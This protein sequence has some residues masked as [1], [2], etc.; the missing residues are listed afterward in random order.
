MIIPPPFA[1]ALASVLSGHFA[2]PQLHWAASPIELGLANLSSFRA[3][4]TILQRRGYGRVAEFYLP[5][6][7]VGGR[8]A[9]PDINI[10]ENSVLA[11]VAGVIAGLQAVTPIHPADAELERIA[12]GIQLWGGKT[13]R[14][15]FVRGGGFHHNFS[16]HHY[17]QIIGHLLTPLSPGEVFPTP[18]I[19]NA[20]NLW[21]AGDFKQIG[22]S[23]ATKHLG[24][25]S[26]GPDAP[27]RLP[28]Y[29]SIMAE[30]FMGRFSVNRRTNMRRGVAHWGD[31]LNYVNGMRA[32]VAAINATNPELEGQYTE[33]QLERQLFV[34][35]GTPA[36]EAWVRMN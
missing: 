31:Y 30:K 27:T 6:L 36:A 35:A 2:I 22:V 16:F 26:R 8:P 23:F 24:F 1:P 3:M 21:E 7:A 28:I 34:W 32:A 12:I 4:F 14:S 19:H 13:G 18:A 9:A 20:L 29:D 15:L 25:W 17:R 33:N 10:L 5:H 11:D